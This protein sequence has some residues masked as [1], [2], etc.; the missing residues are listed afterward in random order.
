[1]IE[2][3]GCRLKLALTVIQ[4]LSFLLHVEVYTGFR[5][6]VNEAGLI[7]SAFFITG[8]PGFLEKIFLMQYDDADLTH[9]TPGPSMP[10]GKTFTTNPT[11]QQADCPEK[12][13]RQAAD[14]RQARR[15]GRPIHP[16][17]LRSFRLSK[18]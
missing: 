10:G 8:E 2:G 13:N 18:H 14:N 5:R 11:L 15:Q 6:E 17:V 3:R 1:M 4:R 12:L 9:V 7:G 16:G